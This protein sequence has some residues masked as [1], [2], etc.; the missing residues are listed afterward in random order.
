MKWMQRLRQT[1]RSRSHGRIGS[2]L[3][4]PDF[5]LGIPLG[6][7]AASSS[8]VSQDVRTALPSVLLAVAGVGAAVATLVLTSLAV[9]L[10]TV[11]P[12]YRRL[13]TKVR[14]GVIGTAR[15]FKVVVL[16]SAATTAWSLIAAGFIPLLSTIG[17]ATFLLATP[18]F[19]FLLWAVFGCVQITDQIIGH[20][21]Q[22]ERAEELE[23]RRQQALRRQG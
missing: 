18:A 7:T 19:S 17:W 2:I 1:L 10:G 4:S 21:A 23:E 14:G 6:A 3:L 20:W 5:Y 22:R 9:L 11:T 12:A 15:P 8:L 16:V 13:L